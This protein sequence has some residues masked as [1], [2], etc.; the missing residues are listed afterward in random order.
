MEQHQI[1][2]ARDFDK[3]IS[4]LIASELIGQMIRNFAQTG[5]KF[6]VVPRSW[7]VKPLKWYIKS[8]IKNSGM[9]REV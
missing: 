5:Y 9:L 1:P 6:N 3:F 4:V 2:C 8:G 7:E